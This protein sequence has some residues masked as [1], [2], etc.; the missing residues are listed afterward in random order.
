MGVTWPRPRGEIVPRFTKRV[1]W[2]AQGSTKIKTLVSTVLHILS[3]DD[4][5]L[6]HFAEDEIVFPPAPKSSEITQ[7]VKVVI[8]MEFPIFIELVR[9]VRFS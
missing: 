4:M 3:R 2:E 5:P 9:S 8:Y 7:N 1:A 6:I